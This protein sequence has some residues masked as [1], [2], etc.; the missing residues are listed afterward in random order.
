M[1][2]IN[3]LLFILALVASITSMNAQARR[4]LEP[5]F[6][7]FSVKKD[8]V[9][10][11]NLSV[12][13]GTPV[14]S[15]LKMDVYTPVGDVATNR[16][17]VIYIHTGSFLPPLING[18]ITGARSDSSVVEMCR[19][20]A[21]LGYV[22]IAA[23]YRAGWNPVGDQNT[24][25]GTLLGA[26]YR[27]IQDIRSLIRFLRKSTAVD[28]N[29]YGIDP[30]K[31]TLWGQ[32]TGGYISLGCAYLD[33]FAKE[34]AID[35]FINT[36]T[37]KPFVDTTLS[38]NPFGTTATP[39]NKVNSPGY[40]SDF[41]ICVNMGG[42][43]GDKS[44][45]EGKPNEPVLIGY[46]VLTDPF[47]P[48]ADGAVIVPTTRE[49]VVNVS[50]TRTLVGLANGY[51]RNAKVASANSSTDP[52]N[53]RNQFYK[54]IP[55]TYGG[56]SITL[57]DD[58]MYPF[59]TPG[60]RFEAGPWDWWDTTTLKL[61]VAGT[62][63]AIGSNYSA[64]KLHSDALLTNPNMTKAKGMAYLDTCM[65]VFLPRA[66]LALNLATSVQEVISAEKVELKFGPNPTADVMW[67]QS[68]AKSKMLDIAIY[69]MQGKMVRAAMDINSSSYEFN[70]GNLPAGTYVMQ[71]R[72]DEG[73]VAK[74]ISV[75]Q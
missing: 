62:N 7:A 67:F 6:S 21:R 8:V 39:L 27:G 4:F 25:T 61:V 12:L 2:Q 74:K 35:K 75:T 46:H 56:Q 17:V 29:P 15:D 37:L 70:R 10:A 26:A 34:V 73:I 19:R 22:A 13:T 64:S 55:I 53:L 45:M 48:F 5:V 58:N 11:N 51:G 31:I 30:N 3:R 14:A 41:A 9:Y 49:F 59:L 24:R 71:I 18:G 68:S 66:F 57:S 52:V 33:N 43:L 69:D 42:A 28:G 38:S 60:N 23:T 20:F 50:G 32:G 44:W 54:K 63:A 65:A 47:A 16:P 1:K 72:F 40:S 36:A